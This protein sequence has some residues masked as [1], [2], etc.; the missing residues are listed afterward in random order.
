MSGDD[1]SGMA[2]VELTYTI[3]EASELWTQIFLPLKQGRE[4]LVSK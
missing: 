1:G 3:G 2:D 4:P